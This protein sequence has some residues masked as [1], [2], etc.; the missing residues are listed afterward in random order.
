MPTQKPA[1]KPSAIDLTTLPRPGAAQPRVLPAT[2]TILDSTHGHILE[3]H[4]RDHV[5]NLLLRFKDRDIIRTKLATLPCTIPSARDLRSEGVAIKSKLKARLAPD[6]RDPVCFVGLSAAGCRVLGIDLSKLSLPFGEGFR[7]R[8]AR[9]LGWLDTA[10]DQNWTAD[11]FDA[12][13]VCAAESPGDLFRL[14][15]KLKLHFGS[16]ASFVVEQTA[17]KRVPSQA[18]RKSAAVEHF[19]FADGISQ[20]SLLTDDGQASQ[21][22]DSGY[23]P[24]AQMNVVLVH[25]PLAPDPGTN[26]G[27][28]MAYLKIEQHVD[29]FEQQVAA[30]A[31]TVSPPPTSGLT[32]EAYAASL[33]I[34]RCR[35]GSPL[36]GGVGNVNDF[37]R[38]LDPNG[39]EWL[40]RS[41]ICKMNPRDGTAKTFIVRRG[42]TYDDGKTKGLLFQSFQAD[43]QF[44][45]EQL[46]SAWAGDPN[47]PVNNAGLDP[48]LARTAPSAPSSDLVTIRGGEYFYFPS[49]PAIQAL[50]AAAPT[51]QA[52]SAAKK[53]ARRK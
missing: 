18:L 14:L 38:G 9:S 1:T 46:L 20:P 35:D 41:H 26:F 45:F 43:L 51:P 37:D 21:H 52:K 49:I 3:K 19:G 53:P 16:A 4:R 13:L 39:A 34:G 28:Y 25:D 48:L 2:Q 44:Q 31:Q 17:V 36:I 50:S 5:W 23:D 27:S 7:V 22:F 32:A 29:V 12:V 24:F 11:L 33:L 30:F 47:H 6:P 42:V 8:A 10:W 40:F 15:D